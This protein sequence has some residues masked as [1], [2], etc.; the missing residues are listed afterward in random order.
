[1][2]MQIAEGLPP[3]FRFFADAGEEEAVLMPLQGVFTGC[4]WHRAV[5]CVDAARLSALFGIM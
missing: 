2:E 1:M 5:P 4:A 3:G